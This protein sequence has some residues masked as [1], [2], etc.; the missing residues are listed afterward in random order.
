MT[1][2]IKKGWKFG[3]VFKNEY[4]AVNKSIRVTCLDIDG[5]FSEEEHSLFSDYVSDLYMGDEGK[6]NLFINITMQ[7]P[8]VDKMWKIANF[9]ETRIAKTK[10]LVILIQY[11][12][13]DGTIAHFKIFEATKNIAVA[14][15][16]RN[17]ANC[18]SFYGKEIDAD[19][20]NNKGKKGKK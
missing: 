20:H 7:A 17:N 5:D 11:F 15:R 14:T 9:L 13:S 19:T 12:N 1:K 18:F 3:N 8:S 6:G 10:K 2:L 16:F 4:E